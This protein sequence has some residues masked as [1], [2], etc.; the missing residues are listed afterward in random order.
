MPWLAVNEEGESPR[1]LELTT[2]P[3]RIGRRAANDLVLGDYGVSRDHSRIEREGERWRLVDLGAA[4]GTFLNGRRLP[5]NNPE[6]LTPG[7]E[8]RIG[9]AT[10]QFL[11]QPPGP[12]GAAPGSPGLADSTRL[13]PSDAAPAFVRSPDLVRPL[14]EVALPQK[15][16]YFSVLHEL[17]KLLLGARELREIGKTAL[18]L[19]FRVL[20]V[21]RGA[22]AVLG[23]D[24]LLAP[25]VDRTRKEDE[26]ITISQTISSWVL[27]ERV[28]VI[29]SDARH[30]PRFQRGES[31][32]AYHIRSAMCVPL[33]SE[34]D[35]LGVLYLD[36]LFEAHAFTEEELELVTA[37]ANQ[38]A[39]GMRQIRLTEQLRDEAVIRANLSGYHSPDVVEMILRRSREGRSL[40]IEV[41]DEVVTV[42]F[43]DIVGFTSMS[44]RLSSSEVADLLNSFFD[45]M[46]R[47]IFGCNGSVNKY[48]GDAIMAIFGAPIPT[49]N[50]SELAVRAALRMQQEV[51]AIQDT[52]PPDRRFRVRIGVNSGRV[53][54]GNI[55]STQRMEFTVL[56][57]PVNVAQRL[58]SIC[59]PGK[60]YVGEET[61]LKTRDLFRY[62]DLGELTLKGRQQQIRVY[63]LLG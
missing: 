21:E 52:V 9:R 26:H 37:V 38:V 31:I 57:D 29:T 42:L 4:N 39:I 6:A 50:H 3:F 44:E 15:V 19:L 5:A 10:I 22:I 34:T 58:E 25:L 59:E 23:P 8:I 2:T 13:L 11:A 18:K 36:N 45:R 41:A 51:A 46:T 28:A 43:C 7:D 14:D 12:E 56:G 53:V 55:G 33:W 24:G 47:A 17:A 30:D 62:R 35:T 54:V 60:V 1:V 27:R 63:E 40:G 16:E 49:D 32:L 61:Y 48:I 20:S